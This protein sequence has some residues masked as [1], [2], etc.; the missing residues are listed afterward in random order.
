MPPTP[1]SISLFH[2]T[3][4]TVLSASIMKFSVVWIHEKHLFRNM[5]AWLTK[6]SRLDFQ[7]MIAFRAKVGKRYQLPHEGIIPEEF[8]LVARYRGQ[9]R[10]AEPGFQNPRWVD[11][12]LVIL[13]GKYIKGGP[14]ASHTVA[15]RYFSAVIFLVIK[16]ENVWMLCVDVMRRLWRSEIVAAFEVG[17]PTE[18]EDVASE[19]GRE[20]RRRGIQSLFEYLCRN[21]KTKKAEQV[22][23]QLMSRGIQDPSAYRTLILGNCKEGTCVAGHKLL[24]LMLRRNFEPDRVKPIID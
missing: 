22:L 12:E 16:R 13:D 8:G 21:G 6:S 23:R 1:L 9:G 18:R 17:L 5:N 14:V 3:H 4:W 24:V 20:S 2:Y 15:L 11:G 19:G 7:I 10:L